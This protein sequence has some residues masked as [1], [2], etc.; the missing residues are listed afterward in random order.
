MS[1]IL[2]GP[3]PCRRRLRPR[4]AAFYSKKWLFWKLG[5]QLRDQSVEKSFFFE[6]CFGLGVRLRL[7]GGGGSIRLQNRLWIPVPWK[8][9]YYISLRCEK[10]VEKQLILGEHGVGKNTCLDIIIS[11][12]YNTVILQ[13]YNVVILQYYNSVIL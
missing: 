11:R 8:F 7:H 12:Y 9:V 10:Q 3:W 4:E 6:R 1:I 2:T 13:C 5:T